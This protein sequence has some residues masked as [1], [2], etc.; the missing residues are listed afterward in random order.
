[1]SE[2]DGCPDDISYVHGDCGTVVPQENYISCVPE[3]P[4]VTGIGEQG[5]D[6]EHTPDPPP[7]PPPPV[8][9][10]TAFGL[11][12]EGNTMLPDAGFSGFTYDDGY[13]PPWTATPPSFQEQY[14]A[15]TGIPWDG[16]A[17][18]V[19]D[20]AAYTD[21]YLVWA[22][23]EENPQ[24]VFTIKAREGVIQSSA[25]SDSGNASISGNSHDGEFATVNVSLHVPD[26]F[27]VHDGMA[28]VQ[29][30]LAGDDEPSFF[31][32]HIKS[33]QVAF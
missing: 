32:L 26:L 1:M 2:H 31:R 20:D 10:L 21:V 29:V 25:A 13:M 15:D 11:T 16:M 8:P 30:L 7:P 22:G 14:E 4:V 24:F 28:E 6:V 3:E 27:V 9:S 19:Q 12:Y 23:F 18:L 33:M 5:D 17:D